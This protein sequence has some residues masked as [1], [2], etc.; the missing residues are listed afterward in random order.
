MEFDNYAASYKQELSP[1]MA[2]SGE[3]IEYYAY[4]RIKWVAEQ[5]KKQEHKP[6]R[7]LDFGCGVGIATPFFLEFFGKDCR[8]TSV[9]VSSESL[10]IARSK[11]GSENVSFHTPD[12]YASEEKNDLV[13]CNGV[14]HHIPLDERE[15]A[16]NFI[17]NSLRQGGFF[18]LWENNPWNPIVRFNMK[19]AEIDRN[20]VPV[21]SPQAK[22]MVAS[23]GFKLLRINYY[24]IFPRF[25]KFLR[26]LEPLVSQFPIGAQYIVFSQKAS[27]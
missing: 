13:Y 19:H 27:L 12:D 11:F 17:Y 20:A 6:R 24:F 7:I 3:S 23:T 18:A 22:R 15:A 16:V 2:I 1:W 14:F 8:I 26:L 25:L 21:T 4:S 9:D 10:K 5:F